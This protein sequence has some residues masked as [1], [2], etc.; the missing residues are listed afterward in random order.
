VA[1][2]LYFM[3]LPP[4]P[5]KPTDGMP[6][7][8][9]YYGENHLHYLTANIYRRARLLDS[10]RFILKPLL[11]AANGCTQTLDDLPR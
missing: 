5:P 2:T 4:R 10:D 8:T 9:H 3:S 1:T 7:R 11:S 6:R